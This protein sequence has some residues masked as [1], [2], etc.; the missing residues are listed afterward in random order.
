MSPPHPA[1]GDRGARTLTAQA[2][3][4]PL[5]DVES[6][7]AA[8]SAS[9]SDADGEVESRG[10]ATRVLRGHHLQDVLVV[11]CPTLVCID[12]D[13]RLY[14]LHTGAK[15]QALV[16]L[17]LENT[18]RTIWS[19]LEERSSLAELVRKTADDF[20]VEPY[21]VAPE[22]ESFFARLDGLGLVRIT[23]M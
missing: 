11:R 16:P 20:G 14:I 21:L 18:A 10:S 8:R 3:G 6:N 15:P 2:D 1:G 22:L 19:L 5:A 12:T 13:E 23:R 7:A 17:V 9:P 4:T